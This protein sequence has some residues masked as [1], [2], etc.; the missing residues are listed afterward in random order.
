MFKSI[1]NH[2]YCDYESDV[3]LLLS[4]SPNTGQLGEKEINKAKM[5]YHPR[6][7]YLKPVLVPHVQEHMQKLPPAEG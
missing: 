6:T 7:D 1:P 2:A 5:N 4:E 3:Y